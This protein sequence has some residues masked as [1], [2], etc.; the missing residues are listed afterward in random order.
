MAADDAPF[1]SRG[2]ILLG[3]ASAFAARGYAETSVE[4]VLDAAG[5]SRRTFYRFFR[6]K[7]D[8]F[9]QLFEA[10]SI[11]F[12][13]AIRAAASAGGPPEETLSRCLD[14]YLELPRRAGPLFRV[15]HGEASRPG[16]PLY[17]R[18]ERV[19][20]EIVAMLGAGYRALHGRAADVLVLRGVV[21]A[22]ERIAGEVIA[23]DGG[24]AALVARA[25]DAM[26]QVVRGT[27]GA[28]APPPTR[29]ARARPPRGD[30]RRGR[31]RTR[32]SSRG[33]SS[34]GCRAGPRRCRR[35]RGRRRGS[36]R[37]RL[38]RSRRTRGGSRGRAPSPRAAG[39]DRERR[40]AREARG[41]VAHVARVVGEALVAERR[42][43]GV[44]ERGGAIEVGD[45]DREVIEH[46]P[47]YRGRPSA[48]AA[49]MFFWISLEP[50]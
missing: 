42:H 39:E 43:H 45:A 29:A 1:S 40:L 22:I 21:A 7:E 38:D 18:R 20:D 8:V 33:R 26:M 19:I 37:R 11:M 10:A 2:Q 25:K 5:V 34:R 36:D 13:Q 35:G 44:V 14:A 49:M 28:P 15:F 9:E 47:S 23:R 32:R 31:G 4:H 27:L 50:A 30:G 6:S 24:D 48:R 16:S 12:V 3:A 41:P 46:A 17:A